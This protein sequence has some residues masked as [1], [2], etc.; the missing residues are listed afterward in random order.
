[1]VF[2]VLINSIEKAEDFIAITN[3]S[4]YDIDLIAGKDIYLD[5]KSILGIMSC[6][7]F[8]PVTVIVNCDDENE[9]KRLSKELA[10]YI[11]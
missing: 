11:V 10:K 9:N 8:Q 5:G 4:S 2:Q 3:T 1:M 7:I 6:N